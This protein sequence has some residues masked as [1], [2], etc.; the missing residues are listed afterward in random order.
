[1]NLKSGDEIR[2]GGVGACI[3]QSIKKK[4]RKYI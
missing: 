3:K 2:G 1:M 4:Q